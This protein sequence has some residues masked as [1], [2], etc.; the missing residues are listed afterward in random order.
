MQ[1]ELST[2]HSFQLFSQSQWRIVAIRI[3]AI[4]IAATDHGS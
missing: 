4:V 2:I 1:Q 3:V